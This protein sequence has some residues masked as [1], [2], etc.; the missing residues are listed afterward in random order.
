MTGLAV[1]MG[2]STT[3]LSGFGVCAVETTAGC[4]GLLGV[5]GVLSVWA[6]SPFYFLVHFG[7]HLDVVYRIAFG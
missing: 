2:D 6:G 1:I 3:F 5:C 4:L 7:R